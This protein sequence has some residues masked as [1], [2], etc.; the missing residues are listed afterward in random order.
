MATVKTSRNGGSIKNRVREIVGTGSAVQKRAVLTAIPDRET[1]RVK[2]VIEG[3]SLLMWNI[4][5]EKARDSISGTSAEGGGKARKE[6]W[7]KTAYYMPDG[8]T[9]AALGVW[10][11]KAME[12]GTRMLKKPR[13]SQVSLVVWIVENRVAILDA[14]GKAVKLRCDE[15][16]NWVRQKG[17][18]GGDGIPVP[19][20][21]AVADAGW[22]AS[23]TVLIEDVSVVSPSF[24]PGLVDRAG[25]CGIGEGRPSKGS[26]LGL[27]RFRLVSVESA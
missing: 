14:N 4:L 5:S 20:Y 21:R 22:R 7:P 17:R 11:R 9:P 2:V 19:R 3:T 13:R 8:K 26:A 24:I 10:F 12:S 6:D 23:F 15:D 16:A 27:G 1:A 25:M 18:M